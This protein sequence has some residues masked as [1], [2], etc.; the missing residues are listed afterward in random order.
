VW[1]VIRE[2]YVSG[3][4]EAKEN[5]HETGSGR[6]GAGGWWAEAACCDQN[7]NLIG[8][9]GPFVSLAM[10]AEVKAALDRQMDLAH[11]AVIAISLPYLRPSTAGE[12]AIKMVRLDP[13]IGKWTDAGTQTMRV[14]PNSVTALVPGPGLFTILALDRFHIEP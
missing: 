12:R 5:F 3:D 6:R 1:S 10:I 7:G 2:V 4:N 11:G 14:G 8:T 13:A 9:V